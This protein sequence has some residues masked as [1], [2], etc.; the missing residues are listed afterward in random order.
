ME[1]GSWGGMRSGRGRDKTKFEIKS[2]SYLLLHLNF[3]DVGRAFLFQDPL[4]L[5]V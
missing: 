5:P 1:G 4:V 2:I 3:S